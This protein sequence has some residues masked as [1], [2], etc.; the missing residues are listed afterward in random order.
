MKERKKWWWL[1]GFRSSV[2]TMPKCV[3][4]L[5]WRPESMLYDK[6]NMFIYSSFIEGEAVMPMFWKARL[7][8]L[9]TFESWVMKLT[10]QFMSQFDGIKINKI[11]LNHWSSSL[12]WIF[13][14]STRLSG[15]KGQPLTEQTE[16][17]QQ[18]IP[19]RRANKIITIFNLICEIRYKKNRCHR[20]RCEQEI[21]TH[22][23]RCAPIRHA[24]ETD[25]FHVKIE[26]G[27]IYVIF[28]FE[29]YWLQIE[30]EKK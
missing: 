5:R 12:R 16:R 27:N 13:P 15:T 17:N 8:F 14:V 11:S 21:L 10:I 25:K 28:E 30:E 1:I 26:K 29:H 19:T 2:A 23:K 7:L 4:V 3:Y 18:W 22:W 20:R 6:S 24:T 9:V